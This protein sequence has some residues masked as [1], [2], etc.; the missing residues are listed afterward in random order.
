V[1]VDLDPVIV[2]AQNQVVSDK[3]LA[4]LL[5]PRSRNWIADVRIADGGVQ[6]G[7]E[8]LGRY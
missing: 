3:R 8:G 6:H 5:A 7:R 4:E 2:S 1:A